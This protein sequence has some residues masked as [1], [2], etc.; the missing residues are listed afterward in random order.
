M[1]M[2]RRKEAN[3][4]EAIVRAIG[5]IIMLL[6]LWAMVQ[7]VGHG[8]NP[9]DAIAGLLSTLTF[10][11]LLF[12]A[13]TVIGLLVWFIVLKGPRRQTSTSSSQTAPTPTRTQQ[14]SP[15]CED[16]GTSITLGIANYC[17]SRSHT[18]QS[19][20]LCMSCQ[21]GYR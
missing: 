13:I 3:R 6:F 9:G 5:A 18:F 8:N 15:I 1:Q 4:A 17:Q 21:I 10:F 7:G 20:L 11:V 2:S 12:G 16:C 19:K 14:S